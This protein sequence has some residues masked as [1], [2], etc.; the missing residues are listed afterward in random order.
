MSRLT[1]R[2]LLFGSGVALGGIATKYF[3]AE[4]IS[5]GPSY[6]DVLISSPS[7]G[8]ILND[9]SQL[10]PTRVAK[11][12]VMNSNPQ[13]RFISKL[14]LEIVEARNADRPFSISAARHSMGGQS[15]PNGG[16]AVT[17]DQD[18][19]EFDTA[20]MTYRVAAGMRWN[21][22]IPRLDKIGFSPKIMQSNND[23]G[24]ASTFCVNAHGW[25]VPFS[26]FG[27]TV[28]SFKL[29]LPDGELVTCSRNEN[30]ELF[31]MTMGGYGLSGAVTELEIEMVPNLRLTPK[32]K[33]ISAVEFGNKF[34]STLE[35]DP[36]IKMAYGRL[37]VTIDS[38]LEEALMVT[39]SPTT[40]QDLL[41]SV[42]APG[43]LTTASRSMLRNQLDSDRMKSLRWFIE[44]KI[45]PEIGSGEITRNTLRN[46]PVS[47]IA[48]NDPFRTDILH[49]YFIS[50]ERFPEFIKACRNVIPTS[51]QQLLNITLRYVDSDMDSVLSYATEPRIAAVMLFSQ[52]MSKRAEADMARMT[53][54][55]IEYVIDLGGTYYLPYRLHAT[56]RQ[57]QS[58]Y[59]SAFEFAE[60][61]R[62]H[63]PDLLFRNALWDKYL[64]ALG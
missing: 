31:K 11:H 60:R 22:I 16:T 21:K 61:K 51:Y 45:G 28:R 49:E 7:M 53:S 9:A 3:P 26:A 63:D 56:N 40:N 19:L 43:F 14:Q 39:Y 54:N 32:F 24:V 59:P 20:S 30:S 17:L 50:A 4:K 38:F 36:G 47:V 13:G 57:F 44:A 58:G 48:D 12:L 33:L 8:S 35:N 6:P 41:P 25:P 23:F 64:A 55:L 15:L 37:D 1:R 2:A 42:S 5:T 27:S 29:M 18:W 46:E 52:E 10:N 62:S 34:V